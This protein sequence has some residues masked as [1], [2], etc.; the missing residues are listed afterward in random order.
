MAKTCS[1][2]KRLTLNLRGKRVRRLA[3]TRQV[4]WYEVCPDHAV[5]LVI[6]RD[7]EGKEPDDFFFTTD[8]TATATQ[9]IERYGGRWSI[10][11]GVASFCVSNV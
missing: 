4:L 1:G 8:L 5:L 3:Y 10:E 11:E 7:P 9:V 2:W 6:C